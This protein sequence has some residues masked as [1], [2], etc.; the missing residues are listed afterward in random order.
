MAIILKAMPTYCFIV[1]TVF[2]NKE[3]NNNIIKIERIFII[4]YKEVILPNLKT[5]QY[6]NTTKFPAI[7]ARNNQYIFFVLKY[8]STEN[9]VNDEKSAEKNT[10]IISNNIY[11][12]KTNY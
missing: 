10:S 9:P 8:F 11:T 5:K 3:L 6:D 4:T 12:I 7:N 1:R 2:K